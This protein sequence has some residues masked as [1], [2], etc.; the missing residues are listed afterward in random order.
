[1]I[2][3]GASQ[4]NPITVSPIQFKLPEVYGSN[5]SIGLI[6]AVSD[7]PTEESLISIGYCKISYCLFESIW[8]IDRLDAT[9]IDDE[10]L[11]LPKWQ[12]EYWRMENQLIY[13][14]LMDNV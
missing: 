12:P 8:K 6:E 3:K 10:T 11:M 5:P 14:T 4:L 1:M 2:E 13:M 9:F 7:P